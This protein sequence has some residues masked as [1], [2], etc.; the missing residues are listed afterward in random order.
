MMLIHK[1]NGDVIA[2]TEYSDNL[3]VLYEL[4]RPG[5]DEAERVDALALVEQH[6]A[7]RPVT[8]PGAQ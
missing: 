4:E 2:D 5:H 7:R 6:V 3:V 8:T 1:L